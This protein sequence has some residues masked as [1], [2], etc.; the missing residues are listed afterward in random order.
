MSKIKV[1]QIKSSIKRSQNQKKNLQALGLRKIGQVVEHEATPVIL[2][3]IHKVKH[4]V[5]T[6][7][8]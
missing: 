5:S 1:K 3:M 4:M 6:E 8:A 7:E 2:G